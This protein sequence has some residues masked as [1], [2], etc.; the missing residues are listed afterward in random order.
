MGVGNNFKA[1]NNL[2]SKE[3]LI[4]FLQKTRNTCVVEVACAIAYAC[5]S[6]LAR[7]TGREKWGTVL[8]HW[9]HAYIR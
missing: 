2:G 8:T 4:S 7:G 5:H 9:L 3:A 6:R 1:Y